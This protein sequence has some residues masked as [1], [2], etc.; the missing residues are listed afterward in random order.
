MAITAASMLAAT[1]NYYTPTKVETMTQK[2]FPFMAMV[3]KRT[4]LVSSQP[5]GRPFINVMIAGNGASGSSDFPTS[6]NNS[7]FPPLGGFQIFSAKDYSTPTI[8]AATIEATGD[9]KGAF[10]GV[11]K[12]SIDAGLRE[13]A[14]A[15][16]LNMVGDG[17][18]KRGTVGTV[19]SSTQFQLTDVAQNVNFQAATNGVGGTT[20]QFGYVSSGVWALRNSA[21]SVMLTGVDPTTGIITISAG[22]PTG[23]VAGDIIV[24]AG[25]L[26]AGTP[27]N[28]GMGTTSGARFAGLAGWCPLN[29]PQV[30]M[31]DNFGGMD[32]SNNPWKFAGG[33]FNGV[34]KSSTDA[35]NQALAATQSQGAHPNILLV[36]RF[37]WAMI[38]SDLE[39]RRSFDATSEKIQGAGSIGFNSIN[40][41][42]MGGDRINIVSDN[43]MPS[44]IGY[45][46]QLDTY[47]LWSMNGS[48]V[49]ILDYPGYGAAN[50]PSATLDAI[51]SRLGTRGALLECAAPGFTDVIQFA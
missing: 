38:E 41:K 21:Q 51:Q 47:T 26:P 46:V 42:T 17:T 15:Q 9:S 37:T 45:L 22:I 16:A 18:G 4:D 36:N 5:G 11:L 32:R 28:N 7:G 30:G 10:F 34:G 8:D 40:I 43:T 50:V 6:Q 12:E 20:V 33:K 39:G 25:D 14:Q 23:V 1:K 44:K 31:N 13:S 35:I 48:H 27:Y 19:L 2:D 49:R 3:R 29:K 24:R